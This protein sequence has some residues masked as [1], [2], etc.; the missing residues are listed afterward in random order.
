MIHLLH[1]AVYID[2]D[3][4][5]TLLINAAFSE[6]V[7]TQQE[8]QSLVINAYLTKAKQCKEFFLNEFKE[9]FPSK[10]Q[11]RVMKMDAGGFYP[12]HQRL[13]DVPVKWTDNAAATSGNVSSFLGSGNLEDETLSFPDRKTPS[14]QMEPIAGVAMASSSTLDPSLLI[15]N[16]YLSTADDANNEMLIDIPPELAM[17]WF[18]SGQDEQSAL[19]TTTI[20][21]NSDES[22]IPIAEVE[23]TMSTVTEQPSTNEEKPQDAWLTEEEEEPSVTTKDATEEG[24]TV[25]VGSTSAVIQDEVIETEEVAK[26]VVPTDSTSTE[27]EM[28]L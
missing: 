26:H 14:P 27:M 16:P 2:S 15:N 6:D 23:V 8:E 20:A 11:D 4:P 28:D 21:V 9:L 12:M 10:L 17:E 5:I 1:E 3:I 7:E 13:E 22:N 19:V 18:S 24:S 25:E